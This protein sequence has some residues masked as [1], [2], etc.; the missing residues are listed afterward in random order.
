LWGISEW[1]KIADTATSFDV[2]LAP[3]RFFDVCVASMPNGVWIEHF[4]DSRILN[5][6]ELFQRS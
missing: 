6:T 2:P 1:R 5:V 4:V 3:H